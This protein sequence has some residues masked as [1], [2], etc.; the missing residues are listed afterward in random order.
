MGKNG[1]ANDVGVESCPW[2]QLLARREL[3]VASLEAG[4]PEGDVVR[5]CILP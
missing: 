4:K 5:S 1:F 3:W 2:S